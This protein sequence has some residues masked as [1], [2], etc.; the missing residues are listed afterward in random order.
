[1]TWSEKAAIEEATGEALRPYNEER[2]CCPYL[3]E[4]NRCE[5]YENRP[6]ICRLYGAVEDLRCPYGCRPDRLLTGLEGAELLLAVTAAGGDT[7]AITTPRHEAMI[8]RIRKLSRR[9]GQ[10][11][12]CRLKQPP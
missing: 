4:E 5:I 3:T 7:V 9:E 12:G 8:E 11:E 1:M 10:R 2:N 6:A